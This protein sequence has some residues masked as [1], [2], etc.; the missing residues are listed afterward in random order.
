MKLPLRGWRFRLLAISSAAICALAMLFAFP[1]LSSGENAARWPDWLPKSP[2]LTQVN[3]GDDAG[4]TSLLLEPNMAELLNEMMRDARN[5]M[6][7]ALRESRIRYENLRIVA[8]G[9]SFAV[10][11][12]DQQP[13]ALDIVRRLAEQWKLDSGGA[14]AFGPAELSDDGSI[15]IRLLDSAVTEL[16][17]L[18]IAYQLDR[19]PRLLKCLGAERFSV[20]REGDRIRVILSS[21]QPP[22]RGSSGCDHI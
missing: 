17:R 1:N 11:D 19:L 4:G 15:S 14:P 12:R 22:T 13:A 9:I 7:T 8:A 6:R 3:Q 2:P 21:P 20:E 10:P 5:K 16:R 18:A